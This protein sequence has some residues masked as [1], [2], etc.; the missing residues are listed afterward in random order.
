MREL[1]EKEI[2]SFASLPNVENGI[3][4]KIL[5]GIGPKSS[6]DIRD[7]FYA[8]KLQGWSRE[9]IQALLNGIAHA[10]TPHHAER[11]QTRPPLVIP[12]RNSRVHDVLIANRH[13]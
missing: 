5:S 13:S 7:L 6:T 2:E 4:R 10:S 8:A 3:V 1:T 11:E 12:D 9:T